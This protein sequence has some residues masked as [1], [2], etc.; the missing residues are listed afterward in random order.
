GDPSPGARPSLAGLSIKA[1]FITIHKQ[2]AAGDACGFLFVLRCSDIFCRS[3]EILLLRRHS[4][5]R[6]NDEPKH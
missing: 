3:A 2:K 4:G 1:A 5:F 6:W